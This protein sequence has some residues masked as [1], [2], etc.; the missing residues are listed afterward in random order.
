MAFEHRGHRG[1]RAGRLRPFGPRQVEECVEEQKNPFPAPRDRVWMDANLSQFPMRLPALT[2]LILVAFGVLL[3]VVGQ[4]GQ[5]LREAAR[6]DAAGDMV[7]LEYELANLQSQI[8][9]SDNSGA[10]AKREAKIKELREE[11]APEK[12]LKAERASAHA[13]NGQWAST[14]IAWV[15]FASLALGLVIVALTTPTDEQG[16]DH[17][18]RAAALLGLVLLVAFGLPR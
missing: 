14:L 15:G 16:R 8:E 9:D 5:Q 11:E 2:A 1:E 6:V 13:A 4:G 12:R 17:L 7:T 10:N 3:L 18:L